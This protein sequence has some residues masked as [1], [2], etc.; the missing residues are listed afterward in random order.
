MVDLSDDEN[1]LPGEHGHGSVFISEKE[2]LWL[3]QK[4]L[5]LKEKSL[6]LIC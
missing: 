3:K 1:G 2:T 6:S 4:V 5:D